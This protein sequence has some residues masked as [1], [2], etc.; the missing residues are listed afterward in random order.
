MNW[1]DAPGILGA[2]LVI[3]VMLLGPALVL[4]YVL[5][6]SFWRTYVLLC[7]VVSA[8]AL[9]L[10]AHNYLEGANKDER[11]PR[12]Q[13]LEWLE[14]GLSFVIGVMASGMLLAIVM[15]VLVWFGLPTVLGWFGLYH[16]PSDLVRLWTILVALLAA[17]YLPLLIVGKF[18]Q[19]KARLTNEVKQAEQHRRDEAAKAERRLREQQ[20]AQAKQKEAQAKQKEAQA[21]RHEVERFHRERLSIEQ[22][23]VGDEQAGIRS[24]YEVEMTDAER[25]LLDTISSKFDPSCLLVDTYLDKGDGT[26]TQVDIIAVHRD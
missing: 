17:A 14:T 16:E 15:F 8:Y 12:R 5:E 26:T 2:C 23:V 11:R 24:P 9:A 25:V 18:R 22:F 19:D 7:V 21:Y 4:N 1:K 13:S 20:K 10:N 6:G 3:G